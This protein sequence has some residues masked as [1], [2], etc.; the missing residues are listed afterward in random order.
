MQ[1]HQHYLCASVLQR[2]VRFGVVGKDREQRG[3]DAYHFEIGT[4]ALGRTGATR[5]ASALLTTNF[6]E[7][8]V[9]F[10]S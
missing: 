9:S 6:L 2:I 7:F 3:A 4:G 8:Q 10:P 1:K 5:C